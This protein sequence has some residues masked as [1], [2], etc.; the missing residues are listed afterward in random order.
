MSV[1]EHVSLLSRAAE[2]TDDDHGAEDPHTWQSVQNVITWVATI[3]TALSALDPAHAAD[4]QAAAATY[5]GELTALD[6]EIRTKIATIPPANRKLVTDHD[7]FR[8]FA[9]DY[10]F[11]IVGTVL[12]SLSTLAEPSAQE[13]AALQDQIVAEQVPALFVGTTVNPDLA[14]QLANDLTIKVVALYSDALSA[15]D[16]PA[17]TYLAFMRYNVDAIVTAL[18]VQ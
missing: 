5:Q 3:K 11:T 1:N 14:E 16:G 10:G 15:D 9:H 18:G 4:Y 7:T 12:G 2:P 17:A 8:Y 13:L 6:G